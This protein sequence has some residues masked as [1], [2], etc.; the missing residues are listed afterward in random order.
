[1][2]DM[3][4]QDMKLLRTKIW[5]WWDAWLLKWSAFLFGIAAGAYFHEVLIQYVWV[6]L[7]V[8]VLLAIRP[9]IAYFKD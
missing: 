1:M 3:E 8:A 6:I 5:N 4:I 9:T 7:I 2:V